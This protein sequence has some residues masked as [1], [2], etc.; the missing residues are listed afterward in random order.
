M[1][2]VFSLPALTI[3]ALYLGEEIA[4]VQR[5]KKE[6]QKL[7]SRSDNLSEKISQERHD[8]LLFTSLVLKNHLHEIKNSVENFTGD[9]DLAQ[10]K[11]NVDRLEGLIEQY[12]DNID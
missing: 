12:E 9:H 7:K 6:L 11:R 10:I 4:E 5:Q 3:F 1:I 8:N 2:P